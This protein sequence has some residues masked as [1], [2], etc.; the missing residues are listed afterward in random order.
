MEIASV[1][2]YSDASNFAVMRHPGRKFPGAL[3]QGDTLFNLCKSADRA[4]E[5][6]KESGCERAFEEINQLRNDL[7]YRLNHYK[8][9]L[10]S[11]GIE[12]PYSDAGV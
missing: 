10:E 12:L 5:A 8:S 9:V 6:A 4:C 1:E 7:W 2:V 3:V 11:H